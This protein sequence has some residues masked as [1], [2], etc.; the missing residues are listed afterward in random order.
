MILENKVDVMLAGHRRERSL[1]L[2][3]LTPL[4]HRYI[5]KGN[6]WYVGSICMHFD[7]VPF[8]SVATQKS[9]SLMP[10]KSTGFNLRRHLP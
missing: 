10:V 2:L 8:V 3:P 9:I 7:A 5:R 1:R 6:Q 4:S